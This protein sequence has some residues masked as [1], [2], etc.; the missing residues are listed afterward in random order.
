MSALPLK[1]LNGYPPHVIDQVRALIEAGRLGEYLGNKYDQVHSVRNDGQLYD[2]VQ[3]LKN[4]HLRSAPPLAKVLY[5]SKLQVL[6]HALG[7][8][9]TI[10]RVQGSK[11]KASREIRI[12]SVF[13][14]APAPFLEMIAAHELAHIREAD[15]NKAFYA[16]CRHITGD[17]HQL[18]LD[19]RLYLTHLDASAHSR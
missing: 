15:H 17:Y 3:E 1:Y 7:T 10:S 18:E 6:K 8:H 9:T 11:L 5:D 19:L 2:Y 12:A 16:L 14:D 4:R 13:R